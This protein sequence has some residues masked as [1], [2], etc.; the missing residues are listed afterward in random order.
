M[1]PEATRA[2]PSMRV[3]TAA[4]R[5]GFSKVTKPETMYS[6]PTYQRRAASKTRTAPISRQILAI[7]EHGN[8]RVREHFDRLAPEDNCR[9]AAT[10]M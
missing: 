1:M 9:D 4:A 6:A 3:R 10:P 8:L 7:H 2:T 5:S